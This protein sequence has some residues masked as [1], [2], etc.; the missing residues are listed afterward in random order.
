MPSAPPCGIS[1]SALKLYEAL[2]M[3]GASPLGVPVSGPV[4]VKTLRPAVMLGRGVMRRVATVASRGSDLVFLRLLPEEV[5]QFLQLR[6]VLGGDVLGLGPVLAEV[7]EFPRVL[8]GV[9]AD[10]PH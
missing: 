4:Q 2:R 6:R 5:L 3:L 7:V 9:L 1:T 10:R 8:G